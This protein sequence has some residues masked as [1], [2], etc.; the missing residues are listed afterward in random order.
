M[1]IIRRRTFV[2]YEPDGSCRFTR[3]SLATWIAVNLGVSR[4]PR[5]FYSGWRKRINHAMIAYD[6]ARVLGWRS[7]PAREHMRFALTGHFRKPSALP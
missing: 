1:G 4:N 5:L 2:Q 6:W 7:K 3:E